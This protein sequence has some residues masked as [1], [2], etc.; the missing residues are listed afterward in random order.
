ML[1]HWVTRDFILSQAVFSSCIMWPKK[2][3]HY[4]S[5]NTEILIQWQN[6]TFPK[7]RIFQHRCGNLKS[8]REHFVTKWH[9]Q[10]MTT[11]KSYKYFQ[12]RQNHAVHS[13]SCRPPRACSLYLPHQSV[14]HPVLNKRPH[15]YL[16]RLH[17]LTA[18]RNVTGP[19]A[20]SATSRRN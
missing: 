20:I 19:L 12:V 2:C 7:T 10:V 8:H 17:L 16:L 11:L 9:S 6:I 15:R 14:R 1:C 5:S 4:D 18:L 13:A 3:S